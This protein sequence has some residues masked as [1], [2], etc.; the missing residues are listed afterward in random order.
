MRDR[1]FGTV[2]GIYMCAMGIWSATGGSALAETLV[3]KDGTVIHGEIKTLQDDIYTVETDS[4]GT[5]RV[6]KQNVRTIDQGEERT[7][8]SPVNGSSPEQAELQ[9]MQSRMVQNPSLLAMIL[10]L[11]N[12]PEVQAVLADPQIAEAIASGN[13]AALLNHPKIIALTSNANVRDVI[14]EA[15]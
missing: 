4:L 3:L 9:A 15:Q 6:P 10:S 12:E 2:A 11:Q 7:A 8:G 14:E 5:L 1:I 13:I